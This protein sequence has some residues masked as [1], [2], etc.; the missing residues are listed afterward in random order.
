V[1]SRE[2]YRDGERRENVEGTKE[3]ETREKRKMM[4]I[5]QGRAKEA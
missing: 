1:K 4:L 5:D 3:A 2:N